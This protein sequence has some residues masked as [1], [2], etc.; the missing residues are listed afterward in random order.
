MAKK[1]L[2]KKER[3]QKQKR[4]AKIRTVAFL[5][6]I[7][8]CL[9]FHLNDKYWK[10]EGVPSV[11]SML[12]WCGFSPKPDY[13]LNDG[14]TTVT[15]IDVGQGDCSLIRTKDKTVLID[16]GEEENSAAVLSFL[17]Y[18]E[19]PKLDIVIISHP[20]SDHCGGMANI[21]KKYKPDLLLMPNIND[22]WSLDIPMYSQLMHTIEENGIEYRSAEF[23]EVFELGDGAFLKIVAPV[24][25]DYDD[26]NENSIAVRY[27]H[28]ENSFLFM[29]DIG[30]EAEYDIIDSGA[31]IDVDILKVGHH[32]SAGSTSLEFLRYVTPETAVFLVGADN[33]YGHPR[34]VV[35]DRLQDA[36]CKATY[37]TMLNGNIVFVSDG[38][39]VEVL[40]EKNKAFL[41]QY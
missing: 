3:Q 12:R 17:R 41:L 4:N 7:L 13:V 23:G 34:K 30:Y 16:S 33:S 19:I 27:D 29:A 26:M 24:Y 36:G 21:L 18:A 11:V 10:I 25:N 20:H 8:V 39:D 22:E 9:F 37:S 31:D 2:T 28:G 32:G 6:L 40:T 1:K 38:E 14:E 35:F 15:F 5:L